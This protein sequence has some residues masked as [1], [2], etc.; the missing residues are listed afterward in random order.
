MGIL[1]G[2]RRPKPAGSGRW[3]VVPRTSQYA[4]SRRRSR[5]IRRR[6]QNFV[7]LLAFAAATLVLMF[8]PH[9]HWLLWAQV[10]SDVA[11]VGYVWRLLVYKTRE[12]QRAVVVTEL[13]ADDPH[14]IADPGVGARRIAGS[15]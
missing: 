11:L 10:A 2:V 4:Q 14:S 12:Q 5:V 6:R 7:R 15:G 13:P 8:V 9:L 1:E 3:I